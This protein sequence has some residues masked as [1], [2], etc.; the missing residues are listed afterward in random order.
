MVERFTWKDIYLVVIG[1]L[2][3]YVHEQL[4][5][6]T[7]EGADPSVLVRL[8]TSTLLHTTAEADLGAFTNTLPVSTKRAKFM[9]SKRWRWRW[10]K[11]KWWRRPDSK[12][13]A[14]FRAEDVSFLKKSPVAPPAGYSQ[15]D[16]RK[17]LRTQIQVHCHLVLGLI[18]TV[19]SIL[20][21]S[22]GTVFYSHLHPL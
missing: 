14:L 1:W 9:L 15:N 8:E 5:W 22:L 19:Y 21:N 2:D 6:C 17:V 7:K 10:G 13:R 20:H 4:N 12:I 3:I 11:V 18:F 16:K